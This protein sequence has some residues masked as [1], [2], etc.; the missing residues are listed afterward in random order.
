MATPQLTDSR[1]QC[2][3]NCYFR[4]AK[5]LKGELGIAPCYNMTNPVA[6]LEWAH[7]A[8]WMLV[9]CDLFLDVATDP[10]RT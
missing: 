3:I 1:T 4:L 6:W 8:R 10:D 9:R 5:V 7:G 2:Y